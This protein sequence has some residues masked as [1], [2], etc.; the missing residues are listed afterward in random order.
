[1]ILTRPFTTKGR[2]HRHHQQREARGAPGEPA[3]RGLHLVGRVRGHLD[4]L[5]RRE[6]GGGHGQLLHGGDTEEGGRI[7]ALLA[8]Y[9]T[10]AVTIGTK[11]KCHCIQIATVIRGFLTKQ[12]IWIWLKLSL[13]PKCHC[14]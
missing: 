8:R 7:L 6:A 5:G 2:A 11:Q 10:T 4:G 13:L 14:G 3:R 1:M 9:S 12:M